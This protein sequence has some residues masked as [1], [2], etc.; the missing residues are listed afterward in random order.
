M[1]IQVKISTLF[2]LFTSITL[3]NCNLPYT[4]T[5][6]TNKAGIFYHELGV[7]KISH[8]HFTL[9]SFTNIS[10]FETELE[11]LTRMYLKSKDLCFYT[12]ISDELSKF[13]KN[14]YTCR[15]TL[16]LINF[17]INNLEQKFETIKHL[18][19]HSSK[20]LQR[21]KRGVFNG[22]SYALKW[23]TGTPDSDDAQYYTDAIKNL[24]EQ[25]HDIQMLLKQQTQIMSHTIDNFNKSVQTLIINENILNEN[26]EKF[27]EFSN[28]T[29]D[30][31]NS[32]NNFQKIHDHLNIVNELINHLL[33]KFDETISAMLF[34][35]NNILHPSVITPKQLRT[36]LMK[37]RLNP[38]SEFPIDPANY[39]NVYHYFSIS[40]LAVITSQNLI[41]YAIKLPVVTKEL[42]QLYNLIPLP[43]PTLNCPSIYTFIN[44]TYSYLLLSNTRIY[45]GQAK[46]LS[47]CTKIMADDF[48]CEKIIIHLIRER[49]ICE[50]ELRLS[51]P[52]RVPKDCS[53]KVIKLNAE[54]WHQL[55]TNQWLYILTKPTHGTINCESANIITTDVQLQGTG[56]LTLNKSCKY[57]TSSTLLVATSKQMSTY[58]NFIPKIDITKDDCCTERQQILTKEDNNM[59]PILLNNLDLIDLKHSQHQLEEF[60]NILQN[61]LNKPFIVHHTKWYNVL[62]GVITI[63]LLLVII[64]KCCK[65]LWCK[66]CLKNAYQNSYIMKWKKTTTPTISTSDFEYGR[67][68]ESNFYV[69]TL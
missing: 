6:I 12:R 16:K 67:N 10:F 62:L 23:L 22:L 29:I 50:T 35:Q 14:T 52:N 28:K 37:I 21:S 48:I 54:V 51:S 42:Y 59:K 66:N 31:L 41:I 40:K 69:S 34:S 1:T 24:N 7:A 33:I 55:N 36:E 47:T 56:I 4:D 38:D 61:D 46:D 60:D 15:Q 64:H 27:N 17:Q 57:Y 2:L 39:N 20:D 26:I 3:A 53:T 5:N 49:P 9:L 8:D 13:N 11:F 58:N 63:I 19:S 25:N 32:I 68:N 44:P 18:T 30:A 45:Y 43:S 65:S